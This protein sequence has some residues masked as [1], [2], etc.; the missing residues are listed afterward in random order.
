MVI[1]PA[2]ANVCQHA[3]ELLEAMRQVRE[4]VEADLRMVEQHFEHG[5]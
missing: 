5:Y 2:D 3:P 4:C 1:D